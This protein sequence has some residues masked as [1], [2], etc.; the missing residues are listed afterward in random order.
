M[1][2][3]TQ[4]A[5]E[6]SLKLNSLDDR[7]LAAQ[8]DTPGQKRGCPSRYIASS[9]QPRKK[10]QFDPHEFHFKRGPASAARHESGSMA[11]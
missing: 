1:S 9:L 8:G 2:A 4:D 7:F 5:A 6:L 10:L 3:V 11:T